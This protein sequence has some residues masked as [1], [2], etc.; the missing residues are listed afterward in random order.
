M[1]SI[2]QLQVVEFNQDFIS[3]I[4]T[5][6]NRMRDCVNKIFARCSQIDRFE[7]SEAVCEQF[8]VF[9]QTLYGVSVNELSVPD[10]I[11]FDSTLA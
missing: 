10:L 4:D 8:H 1:I 9:K 7:L 5:D 11:R 6:D 2:L 3:D